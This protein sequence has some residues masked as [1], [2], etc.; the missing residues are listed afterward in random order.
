MHGANAPSLPAQVTPL[1]MQILESP[2]KVY[3]FE[4]EDFHTYYVG[5]QSVLVHNEC[6]LAKKEQLPTK[7]KVRY[8]PP[9]NT[10][11]QLPKNSKGFIDR[12]GNVWTKGSSRTLGEPFEWDVQLSRQG[13]AQMGW[14]SR[15]GKHLNVSLKGRITH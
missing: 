11:N 8:V 1:P 10:G 9:K 15:D 14:A 12:F 13:Q 6:R 4:V 5:E 2:I 3:N 7:G